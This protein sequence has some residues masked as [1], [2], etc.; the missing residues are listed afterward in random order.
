WPEPPRLRGRA[1]ASLL[2]ENPGRASRYLTALSVDVDGVRADPSELVLVNASPGETGT[3]FRASEL[4]AEH[5]FYLRRAQEATVAL[6]GDVAPGRHHVRAELGLGGVST[7]V[8]DED[9][10]F[11]T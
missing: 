6:G 4:S 8:L 5:G 10:D 3:P 9:V 1:P 11:T 7:L 2:L